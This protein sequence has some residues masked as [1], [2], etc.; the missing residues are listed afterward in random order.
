MKIYA[1]ELLKENKKDDKYYN[2]VLKI[3][4]NILFLKNNKEQLNQYAEGMF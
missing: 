2:D 4:S 3:T 1:D